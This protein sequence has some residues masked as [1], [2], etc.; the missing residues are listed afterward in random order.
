[1][2]NNY[3]YLKKECGFYRIFHCG[4]IFADVP[5]GVEIMN[6]MKELVNT[7]ITKPLFNITSPLV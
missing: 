3:E 7:N 4:I 1:M 6:I 2:N 5:H